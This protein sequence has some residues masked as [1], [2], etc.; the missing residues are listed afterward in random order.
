[1]RMLAFAIISTRTIELLSHADQ[2]SRVVNLNTSLMKSPVFVMARLS[3]CGLALNA[4]PI[5]AM[6]NVQV[7]FANDEVPLFFLVSGHLYTWGGNRVQ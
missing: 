2:A 6:L 1:M 5:N 4:V 3:P 7:S